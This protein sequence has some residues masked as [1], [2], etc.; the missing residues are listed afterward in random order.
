MRRA[1][2]SASTTAQSNRELTLV[3]NAADLASPAAIVLRV[4]YS[5]WTWSLTPE[6]KQTVWA[7]PDGTERG[8]RSHLL[9]VEE[10]LSVD[11]EP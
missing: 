1:G 7:R 6:R 4:R 11:D 5:C 8:P 3:W 2:D 10:R 9:A